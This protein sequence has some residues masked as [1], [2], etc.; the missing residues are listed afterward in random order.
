MDKF[1]KAKIIENVSDIVQN[2]HLGDNDIRDVEAKVIIGRKKVKMPPTVMVYQEPAFWCATTLKP[3]SN[4]VILYFL[5]MVSFENYVGIDQNTIAE[6][7]K[8]STRTVRSAI[9][10]LIE[11]NIIIR[12]PNPTDKRRSDYF[13]NPFHSWKG[14]SISRKDMIKKGLKDKGIKGQLSLFPSKKHEISEETDLYR[15]G[16]LDKETNVFHSKIQDQPMY[17]PN[18]ETLRKG[19]G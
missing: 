4:T 9:Q 8:M 16:N 15:K 6:N 11:C 7:L 10:E 3:A 17:K 18:T 14:S 13:I 19:R 5:S 2:A 12:I 1:S